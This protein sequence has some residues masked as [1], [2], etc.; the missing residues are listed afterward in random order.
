MHVELENPPS[1]VDGLISK[2]GLE[3]EPEMDTASPSE[4][5][6]CTIL[7]PVAKEGE[8]ALP[9]I[10][11]PGI[12]H[13]KAIELLEDDNVQNLLKSLAEKH[14]VNSNLSNTTFSFKKIQV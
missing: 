1:F 9:A 11:L 7:K 4:L 6:P 10:L 12:D 3:P 2:L 5:P 8:A 13:E 14:R